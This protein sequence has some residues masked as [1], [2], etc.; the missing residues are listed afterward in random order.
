M[1]GIKSHP[2]MQM[3]VLLEGLRPW[4]LLSDGG[5]GCSCMVREGRLPKLYS[6]EVLCPLTFSP[7]IPLACTYSHLGHMIKLPFHL[8]LFL[9]KCSNPNVM[10]WT[11]QQFWL[12]LLRHEEAVLTYT[13]VLWI[14]CGC[15]VIVQTSLPI[16]RNPDT[17]IRPHATSCH[18]ME[19]CMNP[20]L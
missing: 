11:T 4:A 16:F 10:I 9:V 17:C 6:W 8:K 20:Y 12:I 3:I 1:R 7:L 5:A 2:Q 19:I 14:L 13:A 15:T 18:L